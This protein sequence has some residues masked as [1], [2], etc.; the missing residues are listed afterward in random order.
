M[1]SRLL[2]Q[3][4]VAGLLAGVLAHPASAQ[5]ATAYK[6]GEQTSGLTKQCFYN[7]AGSDYTE[8]VS[9]ASLCPMTIQVRTSPSYTPS[10][11]APRYEPQAMTAYKTGE[12]TSGLTKQCYYSAAGSEYARTVTSAELCPMSIQVR[13]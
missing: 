5:T 12:R 13:P 9:S 1:P 3:V 8:T 2:I 7:F 4:F 11:P 6:T 10:T